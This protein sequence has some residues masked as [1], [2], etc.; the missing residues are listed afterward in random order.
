MR[1]MHFLALLSLTFFLLVGC[2]DSD[3]KKT[4]PIT[5][6]PA[7]EWIFVKD[8]VITDMVVTMPVLGGTKDTT[9]SDTIVK[10]VDDTTEIY[11][12]TDDSI[13]VYVKQDN[14][15][16]KTGYVNNLAFGTGILVNFDEDAIKDTLNVLVNSYL[17][18]VLT[19]ENMNVEIG[20]ITISDPEVKESGEY[21][22]IIYQMNTTAKATYDLGGFGVSS[23]AT[24][25][26]KNFAT[27]K[28]YSGEVPPADWP[29]PIIEAQ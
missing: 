11:E 14:S 21:L 18:T 13:Y 22:K 26:S 12:T 7:N 27:Y 9:I 8:S 17:N 28:K 1:K 29:R 6:V 10:N 2:F 23:T 16:L 3:E 19:F 25:T 20:D 24:V 15:T 4:D 5:K